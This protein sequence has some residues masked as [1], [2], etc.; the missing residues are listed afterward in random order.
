[1]LDTTITSAC[2]FFTAVLFPV[3]HNTKRGGASALVP[4]TPGCAYDF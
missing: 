3:V 1:M 2:K 4:P